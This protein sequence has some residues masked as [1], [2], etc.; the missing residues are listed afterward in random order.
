MLIVSEGGGMMDDS[1]A[2]QLARL[3]SIA[4]RLV[5]RA[6]Q[7]RFE[8]ACSQEE[9]AAVFRLRFETVVK[10]GWASQAEFPEGLERD[11]YD[12]TALLVAG[13]HGETLAATARLV[14]PE[15]TRRLPI[16]EEFELSTALPGGTVD[17]RRA[18]VAAPYRSRRHT[19]Y[20]ALLGR[21]W[22]EV[23]GQGLHRICGAVSSRWLERFRQLGVP[24]RVLGPPQQYWG[25]ERYPLFLD[26]VELAQALESRLRLSLYLC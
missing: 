3:D 9:R 16:E 24:V 21:C 5:A 2:S 17:L 26:G 6:S 11:G 10:Q 15:S 13:W 25:E 18:I 7:I 12:D 22:L 14:F 4:R 1:Q 8:L 19:V 20:E 23:H